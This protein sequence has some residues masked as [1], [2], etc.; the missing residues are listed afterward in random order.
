V[1]PTSNGTLVE[2]FARWVAA[3]LGI[4]Y[5]PALTKI[6]ATREQKE[7]TN[8]LQ[9]Q[10]NVEG[11]FAVYAPERIVG[12][13][14]LLIDDIYDSGYM[15]REV[16]QTLMRTGARAVYPFAITKTTHSDDQ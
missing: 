5:L 10:T 1:P 11:A 15:L 7:C 13:T 16:G 6:R 12:R 2:D 3:Q 8:R 4:A 14:L 9:K